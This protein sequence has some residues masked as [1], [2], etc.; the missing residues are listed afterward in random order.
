MIAR[1]FSAMTFAALSAL[2]AA[3]K[4]SSDRTQVPRKEQ[5]WMENRTRP[6]RFAR[7]WRH[8]RQKRDLLSFSW[9]GD[10][11]TNSR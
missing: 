2:S 4:D 1:F 3:A 11:A 8:D 7:L 10:T 6:I 5:P 9:R